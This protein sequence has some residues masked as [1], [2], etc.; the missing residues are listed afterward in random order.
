MISIHKNIYKKLDY[1]IKIQKIPNIIFYG[2]VGCGKKKILD[3]FL[4]R[5]YGT[6]NEK[7]I[8][9]ANC[10]HNKGIKFIREELKF[11]SKSNINYKQGSIFKSVI[12]FN[13]DKL[14][15]DA[16]SALRRCIEIY[17]HNTRFFIIVEDKTK[18]LKPILSRFC[19]IHI[20]LPK[21]NK[22]SINLYEYQINKQ[23]KRKQ[24][25]NKLLWLHKNLKINENLL[26]Y[27]NFTNKIYN[28]GY[29]LFD[30]FE[31]LENKNNI[32]EEQKYS[33]LMYFD[34]IRIEFR[35]EK[36]IMIKFLY[37]LFLR[38]NYDLENVSFI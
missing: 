21:I 19:E 33:L 29:N 6:F 12:L 2:N 15:N 23:F 37:F 13:A 14:T 4:K 17:S 32:N 24:E 34:K 26:Y 35:N 8:L 25:Q 5:I 10:G 31:Y 38:P 36:L 1:F 28:K 16:Q 11:F 3:D 22:R 18:L 9:R 7:Y 27:V 30:L 20:P